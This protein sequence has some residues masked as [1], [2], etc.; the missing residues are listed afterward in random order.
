MYILVLLSELWFPL[1]MEFLLSKKLALITW[2]HKVNIQAWNRK[3]TNQLM[4]PLI[5]VQM[6]CF[7]CRILLNFSMGSLSFCPF[8]RYILLYW[9][10]EMRNLIMCYVLWQTCECLFNIHFAL[11]STT[12]FHL[13]KINEC[14][15]AYFLADLHSQKTVVYL[16]KDVLS[17]LLYITLFH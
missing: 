2:Y 6:I 12:T 4:M 9:V 7:K 8:S 5:L 16:I 17:Y 15:T 3:L 10:T 1:R 11:S 14:F 13:Q